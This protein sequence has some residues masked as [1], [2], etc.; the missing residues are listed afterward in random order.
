MNSRVSAQAG[1]RVVFDMRSVSPLHTLVDGNQEAAIRLM[2]N[3]ILWLMCVGFLG[4]FAVWY[5][6]VKWVPLAPFSRLPDPVKVITEWFNPNPVFGI[7]IFV[8]T[9][10]YGA[11]AGYHGSC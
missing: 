5:D 6:S 11:G 7:S 9:Y 1:A 4:F 8:K 3:R 10:Y 2:Q